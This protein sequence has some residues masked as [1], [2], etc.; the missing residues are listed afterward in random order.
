MDFTEHIK[1]NKPNASTGTIKTYNSL[2]KTIYINC[3]GNDKTPD[4]RKFSKTDE[5]INFLND[6]PFN[7]RKTYLSA[8]LCIEPNEKLYKTLMLKDIKEYNDNVESSVKTE[9]LKDN[10]IN[11]DEIEEITNKLKN[12][13]ELLFKKVSHKISDLMEIQNYIIFCLYN[14]LYIVPRRSLDYVNMKISNFNPEI[15]NYIDIKKGRMVFNRFKTDKFKGQQILEIPQ[16]LKKILIKWILLIP[17]DIDYLFFNKKKEPLTAVTL[18]QRLNGIF[19]AK[20]SVN[21][22]RHAFLTKKYKS[23][24]EENKKMNEDMENMGSSSNMANNYIKL[25]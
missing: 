6:K 22:F 25:N 13:A 3:F 12:N 20:K 7:A 14:G 23:T 19:D 9:K 16:P 1:K 21:S 24:M 4:L 10:E 15:D 8:L 18:N 5:I 17:D 2:L 11:D